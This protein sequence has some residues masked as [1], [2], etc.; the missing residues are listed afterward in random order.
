MIIYAA[1]LD[2]EEYSTPINFH[3]RPYFTLSIAP[4]SLHRSLFTAVLF[5]TTLSWLPVEN[6]FVAAEAAGERH[7]EV[8]PRLQHLRRAAENSRNLAC[9]CL[10]SAAAAARSAP[11]AP[12]KGFRSDSISLISFSRYHPSGFHNFLQNAPACMFRIAGTLP[13]VDP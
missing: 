4:H 12:I 11:A 9:R 6:R 1:T 5:L 10:K 2:G 7:L 8:L 3:I 13:F